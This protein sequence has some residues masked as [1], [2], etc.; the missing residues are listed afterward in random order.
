MP[1]TPWGGARTIEE[2]TVKQVASGKEFST[3]VELLEAEDGE[4]LVRFSYSTND[5]SRRGPVTL[6]GPDI[7]RLKKALAKAPRL[8]ELLDWT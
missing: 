4:P 2:I 1:N 5:T 3:R 7:Q 6:R 8:R